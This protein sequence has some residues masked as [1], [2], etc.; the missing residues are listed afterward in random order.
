MEAHVHSQ[1]GVAALLRVQGV[2]LR[3]SCPVLG[4]RQPTP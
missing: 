1:L 4:T 2:A 3:P